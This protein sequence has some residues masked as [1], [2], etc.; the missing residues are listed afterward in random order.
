MQ[1]ELKQTRLIQRSHDLWGYPTQRLDF[2]MDGAIWDA[3]SLA[4]A[5]TPL[6]PVSADTSLPIGAPQVR[7]S[8]GV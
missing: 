2:V 5:T 1:V 7:S 3:H 6:S 8:A 4:V